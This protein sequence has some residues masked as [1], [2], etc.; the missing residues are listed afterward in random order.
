MDNVENLNTQVDF[1]VTSSSSTSEHAS[2][3]APNQQGAAH[4][5]E[6]WGIRHRCKKQ[7]N[8]NFLIMRQRVKVGMASL[9][10]VHQNENSVA[11][12]LPPAAT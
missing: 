9:T 10:H 11:D 4:H 2:C 6:D 12:I 1:T 3:F 7:G 8:A 5:Q